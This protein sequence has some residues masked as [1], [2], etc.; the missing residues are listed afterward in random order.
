M[1]MKLS[2]VGSD[3]KSVN[4]IFNVDHSLSYV[5]QS[6]NFPIDGASD[7]AQRVANIVMKLLFKGA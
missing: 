2:V 6:W 5:S 7:S 1:P 3:E 4:L